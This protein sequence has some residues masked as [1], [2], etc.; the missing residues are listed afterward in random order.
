MS[1]HKF[2]IFNEN[3]T[4]SLVDFMLR[5]FFFRQLVAYLEDTDSS[6]KSVKFHIL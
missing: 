3:K 1:M 2:D 4:L 6:I 5:F